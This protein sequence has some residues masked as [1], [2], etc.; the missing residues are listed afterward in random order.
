MERS[1]VCVEEES[2]LKWNDFFIRQPYTP[3]LES[4]E[5]GE[6]QK[7]E[8]RRVKRLAVIEGDAMVA[9][10]HVIIH[11]L[12]LGY[13]YLYIPHG[14]VLARTD[15]PQEDARF[16]SNTYW[17]DL[18]KESIRVT[19]KLRPLFVRVEPKRTGVDLLMGGD[20]DGQR[21]RVASRSLQPRVTRIIDLTATEEELL[22]RMKP[23]TRYNIKLAERHGVTVREGN[24]EKDLDTFFTVLSETARRSRF[25][26]F[27]R[28]HY[29]HIGEELGG[30][31][32]ASLF[33]AEY[34][35]TTLAAIIVV[36]F[37]DTATYLHGGSSECG[38]PLQASHLIQW[39]AIKEAKARGKRFYDLWGVAPQGEKGHAWQGITRFKEGFGGRLVEW[40]GAF[41]YPLHPLL[42][43]M[44][45]L[46]TNARRLWR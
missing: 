15:T 44:Y 42:Y 22:R 3:F 41:D 36:F 21:Y 1:V 28:E 46:A 30:T 45:R 17:K 14:P 39:R 20:E 40:I 11:E 7:K 35:T 2:R 6:I 34:Q 13:S 10:A 33:I 27:P 12:P 4:W 16:F 32:L 8:G 29:R 43:R 24:W 26:I 31:G 37:G 19:Q 25:S 38:R 18:L 23:K 5:W 9:A